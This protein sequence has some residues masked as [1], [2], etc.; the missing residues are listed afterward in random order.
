[1]DLANWRDGLTAAIAVVGLLLSIRNW[2]VNR[3]TMTR[4]AFG[5][6]LQSYDP[7]GQEWWRRIVLTNA[8]Q[9]AARNVEIQLLKD[10]VFVSSMWKDLVPIPAL[11]PGQDYFLPLSA[12]GGETIKVTW[13]DRRRRRQQVE[14]WLSE[15]WVR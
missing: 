14:I 4:A 8:G 11:Q 5:A 7:N 6:V 10:D 2:L 9:V 1:M 15:E 12:S 3:Q 13:S